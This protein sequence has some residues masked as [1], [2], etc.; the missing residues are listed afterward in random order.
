MEATA[1]KDPPNQTLPG[2][3]APEKAKRKPVDSVTALGRLS[4]RL[5][6]L[7]PEARVTVL[8][9]LKHTPP[10]HVKEALDYCARQLAGLDAAE[11]HRVLEFL[12]TSAAT[13]GA[14]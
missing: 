12:E 5:G 8:G 4:K 1:L 14:E 13:G 6:E 7:N 10:D 9:F 3:P 2:V 11:R